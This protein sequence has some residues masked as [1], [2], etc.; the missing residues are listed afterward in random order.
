LAREAVTELPS[1]DPNIVSINILP[2]DGKILTSD[3]SGYSDTYLSGSG[4][5]EWISIST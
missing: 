5:L 1:T 3:L 2:S 4:N